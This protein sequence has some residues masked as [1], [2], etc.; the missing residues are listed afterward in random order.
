MWNEDGVVIDSFEQAST[1]GQSVLRCADIGEGVL[2][3]LETSAA[4]AVKFVLRSL[5]HFECPAV[6][7]VGRVPVCHQ[8]RST[9]RSCST[10]PGSPG[11]ELVL[12]VLTRP[13]G[14]SPRSPLNARTEVP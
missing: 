8:R 7:R 13:D 6:N 11:D 14:T 5:T 1:L 10:H 9:S 2:D 12:A 3:C 4:A